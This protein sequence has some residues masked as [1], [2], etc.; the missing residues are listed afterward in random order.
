MLQ[1]ASEPEKINLEKSQFF[2]CN[3]WSV[4][5]G[6]KRDS[7]TWSCF[8]LMETCSLSLILRSVFV[9]PII[10]CVHTP[11]YSEVEGIEGQP[12]LLPCNT[13]VWLTAVDAD[14]DDDERSSSKST[15]KKKKMVE[16]KPVLILWYRGD[17]G[18]PLFTV[19][20][21]NSSSLSTALKFASAEYEGRLEFDYKTSSLRVKTI[22]AE[23]EGAYRCRT[24]YR[25]FRTQNFI[26]NL[27]VTGESF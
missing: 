7:I 16:E 15:R 13:S 9:S 26:L 12:V 6:H 4:I 23:D 3:L 17:S 21:R 24:D 1:E 20:A 14:D 2:V 11:G 19:D 8:D 25:K 18:V 5:S 27:T 10:Y 22:F